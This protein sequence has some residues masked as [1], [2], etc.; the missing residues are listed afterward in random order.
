M[1]EGT[2]SRKRLG[3]WDRQPRTTKVDGHDVPY[4]A[5]VVT[6]K[7]HTWERPDT[8]QGRAEVTAAIHAVEQHE[9]DRKRLAALR[10]R[11][12][13]M[14]KRCTTPDGTTPNDQVALKEHLCKAADALAAA[15]EE[16]EV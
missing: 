7:G 13:D 4:T 16:I 6:H 8:K 11:V 15:M 10:E 9:Q 2:R 14:L 12:R 3:E 5:V 1:G